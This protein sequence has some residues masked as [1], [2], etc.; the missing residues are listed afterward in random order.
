MILPANLLGILSAIAS[1]L[2]W[3]SGDFSGGF[4]SRRSHPLQVLT[5]SA[6]S[7]ILVLLAGALLLGE[8]LPALPSILWALAAGAVGTIGVASLYRALAVENA[9]SVAPAAAVVGAALPV[10]FG[11]LTQG[12]PDTLQLA[13]FG[14]ALLGI[15]LVSRSPGAA[16]GVSR[17]GLGLALLAGL[18]FAGF[19][20]LIARVQPG[21]VFMPL[22]F[23]RSMT[24][25]TALLLLR[26][27]RVALPSLKSNPPAL[28]AGVLDAGGNIFFLL[29][30]QYTRLDVAVILSSLYPAVTVLLAVL[31][32][33]QKISRAQ[34]LGVL[35]CL[36]AIGLITV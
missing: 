31:L 9:A 24:F 3:G 6:L 19:F 1:A 23:S 17:R 10:G 36:L 12:L 4:A 5:L 18:G 15:G 30:K 32:L 21:L 34:G 25:F 13:G 7:G 20:I 27:S 28:L 14:L 8:A 26:F 35:V 33:R 2:V 11:M 29:A 16:G 22:V